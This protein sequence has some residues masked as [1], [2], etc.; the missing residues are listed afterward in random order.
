MKQVRYVLLTENNTPATRYDQ[1]DN[2]HAI[3]GP[4]LCCLIDAIGEYE[5]IGEDDVLE[6]L[7]PDGTLALPSGLYRI[8]REEF[9]VLDLTDGDIAEMGRLREE[10]GIEGDDTRRGE[11]SYTC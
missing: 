4:S 2:E 1:A 7:N 10:A 5:D 3:A 6:V 11:A 9:E 8:K